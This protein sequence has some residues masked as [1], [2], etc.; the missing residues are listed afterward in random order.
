MLSQHRQG[1]FVGA[2][3]RLVSEEAVGVSVAVNV[4]ADESSVV[5]EAVGVVD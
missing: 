3:S 2:H 1:I 5:V 4:E